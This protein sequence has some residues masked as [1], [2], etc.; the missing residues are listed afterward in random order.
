VR[1][2]FDHLTGGRLEWSRMPDVYDRVLMGGRTYD[3][4]SGTERFRRR[5]IEYFPGEARAVDRYMKAVRAANRASGLFWA[6]K[7]IPGAL[8]ALAGPLM[9][10]PYLR[11]ADRTTADVLREIT[12]NR[13]LT[14]LWTAQWGDYGLPPGQSSFAIH[15]AIAGHYWEGASYPVGGSARIAETIAPEIEAAGGMIVVSAEVAEVMVERGVATGVRMADGREL[16]AGL[17]ISDA[18]ARNTYNRLMKQAGAGVDTARAELRAIPASKTFLSLYVGVKHTAQELGL[19]GTN[20]WIHAGPDHDRNMAQFAADPSMPFPTVF[21]SFP[22]AKDPDFQRRHPDRCT[23]EV[24]APAPFDWFERWQNTRW[25]KREAGY[26]EFKGELAAR[27]RAELERHVPAVAG[28]VD[29]AELS[30]PLTA[31]HFMNYERGEAYGL[32]ATPER[33]RVRCLTPRTPVENLYLTGQDVVSLGVTGAL[34]GGAL[35]ASA[36]L[37]RNL[38]ATITR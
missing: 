16:R 13:D 31:R 7:A 12:G 4:P 33:F 35:T 28:K 5:M 8:A 26:E 19:E 3:F 2:A 14:G 25:R 9:R 29:F 20:L 22:S 1:R 37:R 24:V 21:I 15:A 23:I 10:R 36:V 32:A 34:F 30:T 27:L 18:G 17:V 11:W 6:A 38:M